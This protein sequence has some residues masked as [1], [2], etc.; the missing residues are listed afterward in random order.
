[1]ALRRDAALLKS[2]AIAERR[3]CLSEHLL[4]FACL[5][6]SEHVPPRE[7][8]DLREPPDGAFPV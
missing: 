5:H 2:F 7:K 4:D 3:A 6:A 1:L 8:A